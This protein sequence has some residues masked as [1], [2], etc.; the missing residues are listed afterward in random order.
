MLIAEQPFV[1][2][3]SQTLRE[4]VRIRATEQCFLVSAVRIACAVSNKASES[5]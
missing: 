5:G 1:S 4:K 2:V 3:L